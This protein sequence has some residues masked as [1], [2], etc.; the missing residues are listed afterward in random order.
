MKSCKKGY[1]YCFTDKECKKIPKG[2]HLMSSGQ[3]MRD[4]DHEEDSEDKS[5]NDS[6]GSGNGG[7]DAGGDGG[8]GGGG[9]EESWSVTNEGKESGDHEVAM[10]QSQL[11]KAERNIAKLRKAL[12][13]KEKDIPAWMQAKITDTAHDTDA[14]AGY[15]DK[16][17]EA[18]PLLAAPLAVPTMKAVGAGLAATGL[19]GMIMQARKKSEDKKSQSVDYGQGKSAKKKDETEI[20]FTGKSIPK[21]NWKSPSKRHEFEKKR[22]EAGFT[23][24]GTKYSN[25][26]NPYFNPRVREEVEQLEEARDGKSAKDK[27]Y[28][29]RDWFKGGG[30]K[31]TGGKYDGK[32]CAKQPGQKTKPF[33][34]DADDRAAMSKDEREKRAKKKRKEDPNPNRK[35]KA[36]MVTE[37]G[38]KDACY[39]KVKSRYSVWPSAYASGALVKCRKVGAKNWGNKINKESYD[40]SNWRDDFKTMEFEF[41]DIIKTEPMKGLSEAKSTLDKLKE[42]SKQLKGASKMHAKQS[43]VVAK[44][45]DELDEAKKCWPGYEK[46]GTKKMFGKTYNNCVKKEGFCDWRAELDLQEK[47]MKNCGC[48]QNPCKTYGKQEVKEDWQKSNRKDGVDGMSQKAVNAYRRENPGSKLKTAVTGN[49]KKGS[50]DAKRRKSF[51]A[52]SKGQQDMHNINCAKTPDKSICKARRRWKC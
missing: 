51:C 48:G 2:W 47:K 36:K 16:I 22:R 4:K 12:G 28:S 40:Y 38:K 3:I 23:S 46:K 39:H 18:V 19:A 27:G 15:A 33:C 29:L 6:N 32:P 37:E 11:A 42:V 13:K 7:S 5:G 31:Q 35:G 26:V 45:A 1:Y 21:K 20:G 25:D 10:A 30:W 8:G 41:V 44:C 34:R 14:A 49:P 43:K 24:T 17:N 52:R 9:V 50:K